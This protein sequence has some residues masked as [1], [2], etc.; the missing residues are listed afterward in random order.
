LLRRFYLREVPAAGVVLATLFLG[1][2]SGAVVSLSR[3][4]SQSVLAFAVLLPV[5]VLGSFVAYHLAG[6]GRWWPPKARW[7]PRWLGRRAQLRHR[8]PP[9]GLPEARV[10]ALPG[11]EVIE[12]IVAEPGRLR[13]GGEKRE[14]TLF[15]SDIEKFSSFSEKLDP[16]R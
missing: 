3:K 8:G 13:L 16:R 11:R 1:L 14:L 4:A 5:P 7:P 9:E 10:Q 6:G 2:L 15:F 12:Q